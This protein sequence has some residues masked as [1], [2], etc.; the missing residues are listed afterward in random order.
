MRS[1]LSRNGFDCQV[2]ADDRGEIER[3]SRQPPDLVL[4]EIGGRPDDFSI[5]ELIS[6]ITPSRALPIIALITRQAVDKINHHLDVDDFIIAPYDTQELTLRVK[7][8]LHKTGNREDRQL[9]RCDDLILDEAS[10]EV[11]LEGRLVELTFRE[12]QL[13]RFLVGNRGRVFSREAL[14]DRVW[15]Y[16]YYGGDRTVDVHIRRLRSKIEDS[17]HCFIETV[18]NIGY[19]FKKKDE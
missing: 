15:G 1:N 9:L 17:K 13:L 19:R 10:C 2:I 11:T 16:D 7:Q 12:Y 4:L 8:L 14:L 3:I 18:R 5:T 6:G